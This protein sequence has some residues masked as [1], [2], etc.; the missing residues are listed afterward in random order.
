MIIIIHEVD[1]FYDLL[2]DLRIDLKSINHIGDIFPEVLYFGGIYFSRNFLNNS[3]SVYRG[4]YYPVVLDFIIFL[5]KTI[6]KALIRSNIISLNAGFPVSKSYII[7]L[8]K[9]L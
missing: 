5:T 4:I 9:S 7:P 2:V 3:S 1:N 6:P 8:L